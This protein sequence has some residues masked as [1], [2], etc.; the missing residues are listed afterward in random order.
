MKLKFFIIIVFLILIV[1]PVY[2]LVS[3]TYYLVE[4]PIEKNL[5]TLKSNFNPLSF[6][7]KKKSSDGICPPQGC[8]PEAGSENISL[9]LNDKQLT[10]LLNSYTPPWILVTDLKAE[11]KDDEIFFSGISFNPLLA[12]RISGSARIAFNHIS[13]IDVY[14]GP[15]KASDK[16]LNF[17]EANGNGILDNTFTKNKVFLK[18]MALND[19]NLVIEATGPNGLIQQNG[20]SITINLQ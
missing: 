18:S 6:F 4:T 11:I 12:G 10:S 17:I 7:A 9:R 2:V 19:N 20:D 14:V 3:P 13:I 5:V 8:G 1:F 15:N 16:T